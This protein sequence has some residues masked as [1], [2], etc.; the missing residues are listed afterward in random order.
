MITGRRHTWA[1]MFGVGL[2][3]WLLTV[4]VTFLTANPTLVPTLVLLGS[5]LVPAS[6]VAW[7]FERRLSAEVTATLVLKTFVVGGVL[8]VL[9]ASLLESYLL[10]PSA[11]LFA[12]VG[13]IEEAVKLLALAALTR[14]LRV[15]APRDG[16]LLGACVGFGFSV[17]ESAGYAL[18]PR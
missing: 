18:L 12:S 14:G 11:G 16:M 3:L 15:K 9:A 6:F 17:F 5:F 7:A 4:V 13:L 1:Q 10:R 8:G 2:A